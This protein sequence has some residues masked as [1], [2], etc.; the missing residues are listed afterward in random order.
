MA[1][2]KFAHEE[3]Y[4]GK[5][6]LAKAASK[7][8]VICGVGALGSNLADMLC[9]QG[10]S[11]IRIID[12]DRVETHNINT[13]IYGEADVGAMKVVAARNRLFRDT[14]VEVDVFDKE[15]TSGTTKKALKGADL[16]VDTFDN[17]SSRALVTEYCKSSKIDCLHGGMF[18]GY[19]EIVWNEQYMVP[20]DAPADAQD[21][22]D[23]PLARN[24]VMLVT[25]ILAEEVSDYCLV[26]KP[27][28]SSWSIT[29]KDLAI[30]KY[31]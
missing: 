22:C 13:Q 30:N 24:L 1:T 5:D 15:L 10:F 18:E 20:K 2:R 17:R 21:V 27:R 11:K 8:V 23:Y 9:R 25:T 16:V 6:M 14:Q 7:Q 31:R 19:G 29:L 3:S 28:K 26:K 12:M 4:R